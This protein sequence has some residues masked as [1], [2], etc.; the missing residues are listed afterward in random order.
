MCA[1]ELY[2]CNSTRQYKLY[3]RAIGSLN[4]NWLLYSK[5]E[6]VF[7]RGDNDQDFSKPVARIDKP[8]RIWLPALIFNS[9]NP[10][11]FLDSGNIINYQ[12]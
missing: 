2:I 11:K 12:R 7:S 3:K 8:V 4:D 1:S 5:P 6:H 10:A 9:I